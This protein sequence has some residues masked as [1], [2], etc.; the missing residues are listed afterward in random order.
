MLRNDAPCL[1][2]KCSIAIP[3][4]HIGLCASPKTTGFV[5]MKNEMLTHYTL[6]AVVMQVK[7][8]LLYFARK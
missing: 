2:C 8:V 4:F 1:K 5:D 6:V 3:K 7:Q